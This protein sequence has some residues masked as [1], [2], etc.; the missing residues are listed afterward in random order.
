M[1]DVYTKQHVSGLIDTGGVFFIC[2]S[3]SISSGWHLVSIKPL[4]LA[5]VMILM[6]APLCYA[7]MQIAI[8]I[9]NILVRYKNDKKSISEI[10]NTIINKGK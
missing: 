1:K 3:L 4:F 10:N 2:L 6:S 7:F 9:D 8:R 5:V